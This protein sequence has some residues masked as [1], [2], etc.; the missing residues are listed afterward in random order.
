MLR[1][2]RHIL[3]EMP[4]PVFEIQAEHLPSGEIRVGVMVGQGLY[5]HLREFA[6]IDSSDLDHRLLDWLL[7]VPYF[8]HGH[9][10]WKS[11][12]T[13][14]SA[15]IS[16]WAYSTALNTQGV[17]AMNLIQCAMEKLSIVS[18]VS[19]GLAHPLD[20]SSASPLCKCGAG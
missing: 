12:A 17:V 1:M 7:S 19:T 2:D 16:Q 4:R 3:E 5:S 6:P 15:M 14:A 8:E 9:V 13:Q 20:E 11:T 18:N 10:A